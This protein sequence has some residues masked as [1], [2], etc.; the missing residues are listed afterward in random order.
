[1]MLS[2]KNDYM[3]VNLEEYPPVKPLFYSIANI[4]GKV[5]GKQLLLPYFMF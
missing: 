4:Q 1:M 2:R 3:N 5:S